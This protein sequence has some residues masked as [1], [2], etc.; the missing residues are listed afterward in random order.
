[1]SSLG[2]KQEHGITVAK[3]RT[4]EQLLHDEGPYARLLNDLVLSAKLRGASDIHIEPNEIGVAL[5]IRV[6]GNLLLYKQVGTQHRES[7]TLEV[8]RIFGLSIGVSG[9]PQ[10]G[11]AALPGIRLD[12]RVS[13]LPTHFGEKVV[14]RLL[15][16]DATFA[17]TEL[18]FTEREQSVLEAAI[19][20]D[21]GVVVVSGPT[22]SG[23]TRTLYALLKAIGPQ[24]FNIVTLEDPIEYRIEGLNQVQV[25]KKM[26]FADALRSVLRQDP[27]VIL[28]GEVRDAETAKLCFQAAETGHLVF[29]TLHANG[30]L[31]VIERLLGLGVERLV[32]ESNL[33]LSIAQRLEQR[34][35]GNC[36]IP[37]DEK[38][39][40]RI[41]GQVSK[42]I[43]F[44]SQFLR[45]K[46]PGGCPECTDGVKGRTPILEWAS[47]EAQN[48]GRHPKVHQSLEAARI[49]RALTG[50]IDGQEVIRESL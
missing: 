42:G 17:L 5:R 29:T 12:L 41:K 40:K 11:R 22:G 9:R 21:N 8:K 45:T 28:V 14:M 2:L 49:L 48:G 35:C 36:G 39:I 4:A 7:L 25:S 26:S 6:D 50:E 20:M 1:M 47:F 23:K 33:R 18:G 16:L 34:V 15:N 31:E 38:D 19:R 27:D 37:L 13:L 44:D 24:K 3:R 43:H 30:A 10:D 32:L 46:S